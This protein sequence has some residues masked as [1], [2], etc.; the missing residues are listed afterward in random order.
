MSA[1]R[2]FYRQFDLAFVSDLALPEMSGGGEPTSE[3]AADIVIERGP[4]PADGAQIGPQIGPYSHAV[5]QR[6]WL[7]IPGVARFLIENGNRVVYHPEPG[8]D[9]DSI[10]VFLLGSCVGTLLLQRGQ[11]VLHGNAFAMGDGCVVCVGPS[12]A[13]K[14]TLAARMMQRGHAIIADDVCP[15]DPEG[16][17]VPGMARMKLWQDTAERLGIDTTPLRRI[18]PELEKF[19]LPVAL[20]ARAGRLPIRAIY[21][22]SPWNRE[23]AFAVEDLSGLAKFQALRDNTYR[24]RFVKG[25]LQAADHMKQCGTLAERVPVAQLHRP[26]Q[27]FDIDGLVGCIQEDFERRGDE[28]E[29]K[30]A[31]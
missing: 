21:I 19:D 22:L 30:A 14:S 25:M 18:R 17:A 12:G 6:L 1:P 26:R 10:R 11:L 4:V 16:H 7:H 15:V 9:E 8:I 3:E 13:G 23:G 31:S 24:F 20:P 2:H 5:A 27:G 29:R 28:A